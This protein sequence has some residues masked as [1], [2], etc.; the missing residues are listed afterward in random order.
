MEVP[1]SRIWHRKRD[2]PLKRVIIP[3]ALNPDH[4]LLFRYDPAH[5]FLGDDGSLA[6]EQSV[7]PA[8]PITPAVFIEKGGNPFTDAGI[9]VLLF[10]PV[11]TAVGIYL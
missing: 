9:L 8:V 2:L 10:D 4:N 7:Y 11:A 3:P 1:V 5:H 6:A